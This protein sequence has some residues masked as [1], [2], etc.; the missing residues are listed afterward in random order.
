M[1]NTVYVWA[2]K[3]TEIIREKNPK[4]NT[5]TQNTNISGGI[6]QMRSFVVCII[7]LSGLIYNNWYR[8]DM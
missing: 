7:Y 3:Q 5:H 8:Q 1:W 4:A 6:F 2:E